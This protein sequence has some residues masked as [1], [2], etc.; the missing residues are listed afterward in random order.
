MAT[1]TIDVDN[2]PLLDKLVEVL[3]TEPDVV[4]QQ[5]GIELLAVRHAMRMGDEADFVA[6]GIAKHII[7][8]VRQHG[9]LSGR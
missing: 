4:K 2:L 1:Q 6:Q 9:N 7:Q 3:S 5:I 8:L